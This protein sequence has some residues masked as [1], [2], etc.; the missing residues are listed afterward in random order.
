MRKGSLRPR[1]TWAK[2]T[3]GG[4]RPPRHGLD[5]GTPSFVIASTRLLPPGDSVM[6][7]TRVYALLTHLLP[8]TRR[9]LETVP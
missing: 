3:L 7:S 2:A 5:K 6:E 4:R 1:W 8:A 9:C